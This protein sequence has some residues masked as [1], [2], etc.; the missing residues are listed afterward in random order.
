ML[1]TLATNNFRPL[2]SC[3]QTPPTVPPVELGA[4]GLR[5]HRSLLPRFSVRW[6]QHS[7][8]ACDMA[9]LWDLAWPALL[10]Q[11]TQRLH[12]DGGLG[13][14]C[15]MNS[16]R[17]GRAESPS[18]PYAHRQDEPR[19][20]TPRPCRRTGQALTRVFERSCLT[21]SS[22]WRRHPSPRYPHHWLPW[23]AGNAPHSRV[24]LVQWHFAR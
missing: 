2:Y 22:G 21:R 17:T 14:R 7:P 12:P 18:L 9:P 3:I 16:V 5:F 15:H 8:R 13:I 6:C 4:F 19:P 24:E 1:P 11:S 10:W 20:R 23:R